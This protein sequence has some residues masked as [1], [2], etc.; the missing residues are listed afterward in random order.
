VRHA[1]PASLDDTAAVRDPYQKFEAELIAKSN[2]SPAQ[3]KK[4]RYAPSKRQTK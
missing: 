3:P 1:I 4:K 2:G